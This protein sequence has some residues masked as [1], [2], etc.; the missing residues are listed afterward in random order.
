[1]THDYIVVG[2]GAGGGPLAA[3][4]A[5]AGYSVL[6]LEAGGD[7]TSVNYEVPAFHPNASEEEGMSWRFFVRHYADR[8]RSRRDCKFDPEH[9]G[10]FYPRAGTLGGCTAHNAMILVY[11]ANSDWERIADLT[12]DDSWKPRRMRAYYRR[13]E[14]CRYRPIWRFLYNVARFDV[15][16][17]GFRGWLPTEKASVSLLLDD[18]WLRRMV[19]WSALRNLFGSGGIFRGISRVLSFI[20]TGGDPNTWW[21]VKKR[22]EGLRVMPLT[23]YQGRRRGSRE[24]LLAVADEPGSKLEIRTDALATRVLFAEE[25]PTRAIGVEYLPGKQLYRADPAADGGDAPPPERA[26]A[27]REVILA[28][29]A[30]NTPQLLQLSGIG[31]P[32]LLAEHGIEVRVPLPGVGEN[33]QDRYE[34]GLVLEMKAPFAMLEHATLRPP[35]PGEEPDQAFRDWER[36]KGI[37]TTNGAVM[38]IVKRSHPELENPDLYLFGLVTDFCGYYCGYSERIQAAKNCFTWAILKAHTKNTAGRVAIRSTD[39]RDVPAIDFNYFDTGN[40]SSGEDLEAV[41]DAVVFLR[42]LVKGYHHRVKKELVPGPEIETRD[43][44]GQ[45]VKDNSWGHHASCTAKIGADDDP[46]AVLDSGFRVRGTHGL[47]VVDASVFPRIP[48]LFIVSAVYMIA[49]K[50]S[51][52][53]LADAEKGAEPVLAP[54]PP[55][56][57]KEASVHD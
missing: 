44:I 5:E 36:G 55:R 43:Q 4:L 17:H 37:Y 8:E 52:V 7:W 51:D 2:S 50:A 28:G 54:L 1:M 57:L 15:T 38:T 47:R 27:G 35:E 45:F 53:I 6:L 34:L 14:N 20:F 21:T 39:P 31:P 12:G 46:M 25:D 19:E 48:G 33:L 13:I 16:R 23:T 49:E 26:Y 30:F 41:V 10:V 32:D 24:R 40:D 3:N 18:F 29:G 56:P 11:P 22:T 9:D 42:E